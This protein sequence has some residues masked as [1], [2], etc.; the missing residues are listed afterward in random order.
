M[1][2]ASD[3][4]RHVFVRTPFNSHRP[5]AATSLQ[6]TES[7][8]TC[9]SADFVLLRNA[10]C[11]FRA[12]EASV[13]VEDSRCIVVV[14]ESLNIAQSPIAVRDNLRDRFAMMWVSATLGARWRSGLVLALCLNINAQ[15]TSS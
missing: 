3:K 5:G 6:R 7:R 2:V 13:A 12:I 10:A 8:P 1:S 4:G 11:N 9:T 14:R 15:K